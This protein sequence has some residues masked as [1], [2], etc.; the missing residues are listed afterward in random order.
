MSGEALVQQ[1]IDAARNWNEAYQI[2]CEIYD[3]AA[4]EGDAMIMHAYERAISLG[5]NV[6]SAREEYLVAAQRLARIYNRFRLYQKSLNM[7]LI[8]EANLQDA[9][10]WVS[11]YYASAAIHT[12]TIRV[13]AD[14]PEM[15]FKRIDNIDETDTE[16]VNRRRY[17][18]LEFM[19]TVSEIVRADERAHINVDAILERA[20]LLDLRDTSECRNLQVA[21]GL[22]DPEDVTLEDS[23]DLAEDD[24]IE[25]EQSHYEVDDRPAM[26]AERTSRYRA[27]RRYDNVP[28]QTDEGSH[29]AGDESF[30]ASEDRIREIV[31]EQLGEMC[32][33]QQQ[34]IEQ[35]NL[36]AH[37]LQLLSDGYLKEINDLH[38]EIRAIAER[39]EQSE[40]ALDAVREQENAAVQRSEE[41]ELQLMEL[42]EQSQQMA[43]QS[44]QMS[45]AVVAQAAAAKATASSAASEPKAPVRRTYDEVYDVN[46]WLPRRQKVLVIGAS[47]VDAKH[48]LGKLKNMTFNFTKDQIEFMLDY[49]AVT[50]YAD[51]IK[52]YGGKYAGIIVGPTPHSAAG[53]EGYASFISRLSRE[54]GYP[55]T[56]ECRDKSGNLKISKDSIGEAMKALA[57]RIL[58]QM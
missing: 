13:W 53:N 8:L 50:N 31:A 48:L 15:L 55:P 1:Q 47:Q 4:G 2:G 20:E 11:L 6:Q 32:S 30:V 45:A 42:R 29:T 51:R 14:R 40:Q 16:S 26:A 33:L 39:Q 57:V 35:Q 43:E 36:L 17:I 9:P 27:Q 25:D 3:T 37:Q 5:L 12:D 38:A 34:L 23:D 10:A 19:N 24:W 49:E 46:T 18:Y 56:V 41:L 22:V 28:A 21:L 58:S 44:A 52:P 7:L 54:P